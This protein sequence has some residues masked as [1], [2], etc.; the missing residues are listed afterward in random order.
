VAGDVL[1]MRTHVVASLSE[2]PVKVVDYY[3]PPPV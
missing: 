1:G 3:S 2:R